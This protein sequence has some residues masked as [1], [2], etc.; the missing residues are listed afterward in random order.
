MGPALHGWGGRLFDLARYAVGLTVTVVAL[1][2]PVSLLV[3]T[4]WNGVK[5]GLFL[6]G[7]F[8]FGYATFLMWPSRPPAEDLRRAEEDGG[9][10]RPRPP[11]GEPAQPAGPASPRESGSRGS[12]REE[13][14]FESALGRVPLLRRYRVPPVERFHPGT[15]LYVASLLMLA[16][17]Y[18]MEAF[19]GIRA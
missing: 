2:A 14:P 8:A 11:G 10:A 9:E 5:L 15:K 19:L 13:T 18:G 17:S 3:G 4:G 7:T 1:L 6:V 16:V 12:H